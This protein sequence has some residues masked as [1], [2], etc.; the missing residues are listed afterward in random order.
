MIPEYRI[1]FSDGMSQWCPSLKYAIEFCIESNQ[2]ASIHHK[3]GSLEAKV[4]KRGIIIIYKKHASHEEN[5]IF[6]YN[7]LEQY[8]ERTRL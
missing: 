5:T 3:D 4:S 1:E 2:S 6:A 7:D 8:N